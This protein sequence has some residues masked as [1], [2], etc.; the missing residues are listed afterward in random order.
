MVIDRFS[1]RHGAALQTPLSQVPSQTLPQPPQLLLSVAKAASQPSFAFLLQ[2][3]KP[4]LQLRPH[5]SA[6]HVAV[7]FAGI[8]QTAQVGPHAAGSVA[9]MHLLEHA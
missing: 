2:S 1:R 3:P 7:P 5:L 9:A 6:A 8:G 4:V